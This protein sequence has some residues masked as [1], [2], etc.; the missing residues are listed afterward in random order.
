M[1]SRA[2]RFPLRSNSAI[3][4]TTR[5]LHGRLVDAYLVSTSS[6]PQGSVIV[7][8]NVSASAVVRNRVKRRLSEIL[9]IAILPTAQRT[10][11]VR[12]SG[13]SRGATY[14]QLKEDLTLLVSTTQ[15]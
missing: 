5:R 4:R 11:V 14:D 3:F 6:T 12:A 2:A 13:K 1:I 7:G 9:R 8:K 10:I 15:W